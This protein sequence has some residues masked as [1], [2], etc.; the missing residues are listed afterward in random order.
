[1]DASS[2]YD[3]DGDVLSYNWVD[4]SGELVMGGTETAFATAI[5]P[6]LAAEYDSASSSSYN[7]KLTVSDCLTQDNDVVQI[8]LTC[9]GVN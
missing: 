4:L 5:T 7:V 6:I 1:L 8:Q 9:T 3:V 2:S